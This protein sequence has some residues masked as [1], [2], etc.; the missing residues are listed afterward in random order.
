MLEEEK[1]KKYV[2]QL[3]KKKVKKTIY[4]EENIENPIGG[5]YN[6]IYGHVKK[7]AA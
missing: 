2:N 6:N 5:F 3:S 1:K 4:I 7:Q